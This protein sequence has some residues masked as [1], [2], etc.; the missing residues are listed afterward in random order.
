MLSY[1]SPNVSS[2]AVAFISDFSAPTG[3]LQL[4]YKGQ[5][6]GILLS[7]AHKAIYSRFRWYGTRNNRRAARVDLPTHISFLET[8]VSYLVPVVGIGCCGDG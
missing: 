6:A 1:V 3:I 7:R 8:V 5:N 4:L 2:G